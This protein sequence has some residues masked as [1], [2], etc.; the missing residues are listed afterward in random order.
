[1]PT[2]LSGYIYLI[3]NCRY[4]WYKI[5]K[6]RTPE[7]RVQRL[8]VLLPFKIRVYSI[9]SVIGD[10]SRAE[11]EMHILYQ[12]RSIN[13]EWFSFREEEAKAIVLAIPPFVGKRIDDPDLYRFSNLQRDQ[14]KPLS[15]KLPFDRTEARVKAKA[16]YEACV[17]YLAQNNLENNKENLK[18]AREYVAGIYRLERLGQYMK[19]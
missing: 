16:F 19:N 13:G 4:G 9:W 3:G 7:I 15:T 6:S 14:T 17:A 2:P 18:S 5:G 8:G 10:L 12:K 1:M 11:R